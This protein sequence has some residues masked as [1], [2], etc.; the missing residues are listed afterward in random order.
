MKIGVS[1]YS[2]HE[3]ASDRGQGVKDCI[4]KAHEMGA[5]G[6]DFIEVGLPYDDYLA[7]MAENKQ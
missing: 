6:L 3:Y 5:S 4:Q 7:W 2:F 1:L